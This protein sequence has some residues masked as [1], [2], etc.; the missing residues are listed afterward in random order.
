M[1]FDPRPSTRKQQWV[2]VKQQFMVDMP[3]MREGAVTISRGRRTDLPAL[4]AL[5]HAEP[6]AMIDKAQTR[7]WRRLASDPG[8]DFYIAERNGAIQGAL[9]VSYIRALRAQGWQGIL[10]VAFAPPS[11]RE[12]EQEILNFAKARARK[13]GCRQLIAWLRK[14]AENGCLTA[15]TQ[16]GFHQA[17]EVLSCDL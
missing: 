6:A 14:A 11:T 5:L 16:G 1:L 3:A 9:L 10:D 2:F 12:L 13:R 17:G 15:L 7:H 4:L 8:L